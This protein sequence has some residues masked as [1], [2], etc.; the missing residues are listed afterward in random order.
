MRIR[1][2]PQGVKIELGLSKRI[3]GEEEL[4]WRNFREMCQIRLLV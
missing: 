1:P 2:A 3:Q 4:D